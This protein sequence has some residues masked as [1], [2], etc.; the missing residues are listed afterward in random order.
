MISR[1]AILWTSTSSPISTVVLVH[2]LFHNWILEA[3]QFT[4]DKFIWLM[5]LKAG[6][7]KKSVD[8]HLASG[9]GS[10]SPWHGRGHHLVRQNK[11]VSS[12]LFLFLQST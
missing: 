2:F 6:V 3:R 7:F 1:H 5:V 8:T 10:C 11:H 4:K 9:E 12:G